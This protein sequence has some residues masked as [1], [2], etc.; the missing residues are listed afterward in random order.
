MHGGGDV[1]SSQWIK[2]HCKQ[3]FNFEDSNLF[4]DCETPP[5]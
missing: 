2:V 4:N 1:G 3:N 5:H